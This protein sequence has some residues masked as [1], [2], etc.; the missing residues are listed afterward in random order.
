MLKAKLIVVG[1]EAKATEINLKLP[2]VIG[3]GREGV[4]L[5]IAHR[6]VSRRHTELFEQDGQLYAKDLGSLN[7]TFVNNTRISAPQLIQPEELLTLGN[8]TFRAVYE[9]SQSATVNQE[10]PAGGDLETVEAPELVATKTDEDD[11]PETKDV[12][13][14]IPVQRNET[15][16]APPLVTPAAASVKEAND[17]IDE[18]RVDLDDVDVLDELALSA[19]GLTDNS[20]L[21]SAIA[22]DDTDNGN[23][24]EDAP[25]A[26]SKPP[27]ET[28]SS[29][30]IFGEGVKSVDDES[31]SLSDIGGLPAAESHVSYLG[32]MNFD[33][34]GIVEQVESVMLDI[35]DEA[36]SSDV[37]SSSLGS[38]LRKLPK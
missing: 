1:G 30:I 38:F 16:E 12:P 20:L 18:V 19:A 11:A 37:D 5:T 23:Q 9:H 6:L 36:S 2:T 21:A 14:K 15:V 17:I 8:V 27:A 29:F 26:K 35:G 32:S 24:T 7:G 10:L 22:E 4:S 25:E 33:G 13:E 28:E 3:R 31:V 34:E